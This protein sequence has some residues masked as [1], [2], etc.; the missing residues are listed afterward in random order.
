LEKL[1]GLLLLVCY[2]TAIVGLAAA[3][4]YAVIRIFPTKREPSKRD[5]GD[6][7]ATNRGTEA[8]GRLFRRAKREAT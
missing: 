1:L 8:A 4:T 7:P 6:P 2:I 5:G 3:V